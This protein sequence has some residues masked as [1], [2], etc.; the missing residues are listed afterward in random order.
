MFEKSKKI[1]IVVPCFNEETRLQLSQWEDIIASSHHVTWLFV[2]DGS[3]DGTIEKIAHLQQFQN[4]ESYSLRKNHGKA[5]AIRLGLLSKLSSKFQI[6]GYLDADGAFLKR[7][8]LD[9]VS[10]FCAKIDS[11]EDL[12]CIIGSRVKLAGREI[13]RRNARHYISRILLTAINFRW[14]NAPYDTQSGFKLF[15]Y[16]PAVD[17]VLSTGFATKWF[18]DL[19]IFS[20]LM[21]ANGKLK[22]WEEPVSYWR[23][24]PNSRISGGT[25][26][27]ILKEALYAQVLINKAFK[28]KAQNGSD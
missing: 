5:E 26:L 27:L 18:I 28:P 15:R 23:E 22:I 8:I 21:K 4:V 25:K 3:T 17:T 12:D 19:E 2:D 16:H 11:D 13:N 7:D 6:F 14:K 24:I 9:L 1:L 20:R 10:L